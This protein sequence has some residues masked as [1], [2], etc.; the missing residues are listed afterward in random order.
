VRRW[1]GDNSSD[2]NWQLDVFNNDSDW[3]FEVLP[4]TKVDASKLPASGS[5][6]AFADQVRA[7]GGKILATMPILGWLPNARQQMCSFN[8]AKSD[9]DRLQPKG[10][11]G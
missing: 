9:F 1:G 5:F 11:S 2:Y 10:V 7:T 6:N 4:D 8:Q 3:F